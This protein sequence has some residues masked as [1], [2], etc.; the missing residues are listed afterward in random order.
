MSINE[1]KYDFLNKKIRIIGKNNGT[2]I[3]GNYGY[4]FDG[5]TERHYFKGDAR[6]NSTVNVYEIKFTNKEAKL[7]GST[8][9]ENKCVACDGDLYVFGNIGCSGTKNR[10]VETEHFGKIAMNAMESASAYFTDI[11]SG[12]IT[13]DKCYIYFDEKFAE[14]IDQ[15]EMYQVMITNRISMMN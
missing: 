1:G 13:G 4:N 2:I 11:G 3:T 10:I 7:Y 9:G 14:T 15:N 8:W 6:F 12:Y 5:Y